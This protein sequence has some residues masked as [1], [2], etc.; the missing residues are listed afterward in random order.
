MIHQKLK[1]IISLAPRNI[2][3]VKKINNFILSKD[4]FEYFTLIKAIKYYNEKKYD[5]ALVEFK[6]IETSLKNNAYLKFKIGMCY[7]KKGNWVNAIDYFEKAKKNKGYNQK[8]DIQYNAAK[9]NYS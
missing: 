4:P 7:F 6:K 3:D 2:E 1:K 9:K 5:S 8:W